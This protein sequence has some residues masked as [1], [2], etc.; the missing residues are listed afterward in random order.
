[1]EWRSQALIWTL[2][3]AQIWK[4]ILLTWDP[5]NFGGVNNVRVPASSI[6]T[7]DI[8]LYN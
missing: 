5:E 4:D 3:V 7:P 2:S 6:W 1:M 8:V